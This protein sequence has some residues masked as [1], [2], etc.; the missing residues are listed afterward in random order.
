MGGE[1]YR[2]TINQRLAAVFLRP[3][4]VIMALVAIAVSLSIIVPVALVFWRSFQIEQGLRP[5]VYSLDNYLRFASPQTVKALIN[6]FTV[7][8]GS[9]ILASLT[10]VVLAW[11]VARSNMPWRGTLETLNSV[12]F[13]ISPLLG[14]IGWSF[15]ASPTIGLLNKAL[16]GMLGLSEPLF[17]IYSIAGIIWVLGLF[18]TP[19]VYLFCLGALR[20]MDPNLEQA[21]R[22]CGSNGLVT[23]LRITLPL[24]TPALLSS[25][26]LTFVFGVEELGSPF[27]LGYPY[28]IETIS[29]QIYTGLG[30]YPPDHNFGAALGSMLLL[31]TAGGILLQRRIMASR[32]FATITGRGFRPQQIDLGWAKYVAL[33]VNLLYLS[34]AV[35]LPIG[36][37][38]I[39][40]F[41]RAWLGY[42]DVQQFT[43]QHYAYV[44]TKNP[45]AK[46]G[47]SNSLLLATVGATV[48]M[49]LATV[50]SCAIHRTRMRMRGALDIITTLPVGI[51]GLVLAVG[52]FVIMIRSPLY[53]TLW[54]LLLAYVIR[55]FA[56]GQRTV[57][58]VLVS[59]SSEL[60]ESSRICGASWLTTMRRVLL[61]L[62]R[63]GFVA[64]WLLLFITMVRETSMSLLLS[65]SGTETLSVALISLLLYDPLP[66]AAAFTLVQVILILAAATLFLRVAGRES[67]Q[68]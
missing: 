43:T 24:I 55:F 49:V 38:L 45:I 54:V 23:S 32:S 3:E 15:L 33:A 16:M 14:A 42:I 61:P 57:S 28:G 5:A 13:F 56:Y 11:I 37:L 52:L 59:V 4:N 50:I 58:S 20:Q 65:R 39:V 21:A 34:V 47:V 64:G 10:G 30:R 35:V 29:T 8:V 9:S 51:P 41:S 46:Q 19:L 66:S 22:I 7:A 68:I 53:G 36:T 25:L 40:S 48:G 27:V 18:H 44:F 60:E 6:S 1:T 12:P 2:W 62:I 17:N 63:P 26:L 31:I 67:I